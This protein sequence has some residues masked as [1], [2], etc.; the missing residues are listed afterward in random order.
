MR[1]ATLPVSLTAGGGDLVEMLVVTSDVLVML[2]TIV[3]SPGG[4]VDGHVLDRVVIAP[5][6]LASASVTTSV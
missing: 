1:G 3:H 5:V 2:V 6:T 4:A